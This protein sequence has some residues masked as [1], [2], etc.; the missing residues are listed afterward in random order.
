[1]I[2][3]NHMHIFPYLGGA[4]GYDS[5]STHMRFFQ[6]T[7]SGSSFPVHRARDNAIIKGA[8]RML[9]DE[10]VLGPRGQM[11]VN[12]RVGKFGRL[13]WTKDGEDYW[14]QY[15]P[16]GLQDMN[17]SPEFALAQ[18]DYVGVDK[19]VI[20]ND[21][22]YGRLNDYIGEAV[23]KH[24]DRF[25]GLAMVNEAEADK[26]IEILE[27]RRAVK[28]LGLRGLYFNMSRLF[29]NDY[30]D[31]LDSEKFF[32]F[33][34]EVRALGIPVYW[35]VISP[36]GTPE[37]YLEQMRCF[38]NW[39]RRFPEIPC[40]LIQS[41]PI[42]MFRGADLVVRWPDELIEIGRKPNIH[43]D[44][45]YPIA[46]GRL[47]D[48]PYPQTQGVVRQAYEKLGPEK[49]LWGSDMPN[50]ERYCTYR[51][52]LDYLRCYCDFVEPVDMDLILGGNAARLF[53]ANG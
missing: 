52:C 25:I 35:G 7:M 50:V 43:L 28:E 49:L 14:I 23:R 9:W 37:G 39:T 2:I 22:M 16:V 10:K 51:Q 27:L 41:F 24:P 12:F 44:I 45:T 20:H 38:D 18:M 53:K 42:G 31:R 13:E 33:W 32:P 5:V 21:Y 34:E 17:A 48:Y 19:A 1:M 40:V 8:V 6:K 11:D 46:E 3:D 15:M 30:R 29:V 26:D 4:S 47:F 36:D